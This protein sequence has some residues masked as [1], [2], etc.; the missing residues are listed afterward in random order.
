MMQKDAE[1]EKSRKIGEV[2]VQCLLLDQS[3]IYE[4]ATLCQITH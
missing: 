2:R 3:D 4:N 1:S